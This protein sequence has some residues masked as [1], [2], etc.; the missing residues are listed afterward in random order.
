MKLDHPLSIGNAFDPFNMCE[1]LNVFSIP[2]CIMVDGQDG[3]EQQTGRIINLEEM[4]TN[5]VCECVVFL[6]FW[7][8]NGS[9]DSTGFHLTLKHFLFTVS[10]LQKSGICYLSA[11]R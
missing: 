4:P 10:S 2:T 11:S 8:F 5:I 6:H 9:Y 7:T 3:I 1:L